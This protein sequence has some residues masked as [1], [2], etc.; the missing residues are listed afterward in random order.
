MT[1]T[2]NRAPGLGRIAAWLL[3]LSMLVPLGAA[4][5]QPIVEV[6]LSVSVADDGVLY[7]GRGMNHE[8][9][10]GVLHF[11]VDYAFRVRREFPEP[12]KMGSLEQE[13]YVK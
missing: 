9:V 13:G 3:A 7:Q 8:I 1:A 6:Y 2:T 11:F 10:D 5:A 4:R 12:P